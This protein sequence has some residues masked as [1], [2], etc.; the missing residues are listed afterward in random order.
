M[1][2]AGFIA[3]LF[4]S[5]SALALP[6][7]V[8]SPEQCLGLEKFPCSVRAVKG[9][10]S[11]EKG[12]HVF[13]LESDSS[14]S[15]LSAEEFQLLSGKIW[16]EKSEQLSLKISPKLAVTL[17]GEFMVE[18]I[19]DRV[20]VKNL[21]GETAFRSPLVF[22]SESLPIGFE[23]WYGRIT[24]LGSI[25]RGIIKPI[26]LKSF[27]VSWLPLAQNSVAELKKKVAEFRENWSKAAEQSSEL[28]KEVVERRMASVAAKELSH[29]QQME[30]TRKAIQKIREMYRQKNY[31][32]PSE[33]A[34]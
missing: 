9:P 10:I 5:V 11:L 3:V 14:L 23:N 8:D 18:K 4:A 29:Q 21:N 32:E 7:F 2:F 22:Q 25:E 15:F 26:E 24:T 6:S 20:W 27:L 1:K 31:L 13:V 28:Y 33:E 34:P 12:S 19:A 30:K 17:T 16:I